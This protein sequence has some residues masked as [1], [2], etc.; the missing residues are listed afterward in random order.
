M[1]SFEGDFKRRPV[2]SLRGASKKEPTSSLLQRN[3]DERK[4]RQEERNKQL[5][6]TR[7]QS[8]LRGSL[9]RQ[10]LKAELRR[11]WDVQ[12]GRVQGGSA[13]TATSLD[14][15]TLLA[16]Q[17]HLVMFFNESVDSQRLTVLCQVI[18]KQ[19]SLCTELLK[20]HRSTWI[21]QIRR[22]LLLCCRML[23]GNS[24]VPIAMPLRMLEVFTD[25]RVFSQ[26]ESIT[27]TEISQAVRD[28]L[29]YLVKQGYY[30]YLR[31][32]ID[33]R[34]P[35]GM[36]YPN[37]P[38]LAK[39]ALELVLR[40]TRLVKRLQEQTTS[41]NIVLCSLCKELLCLQFTEPINSF[42]LPAISQSP[43]AFPVTQLLQAIVS[44][45]QNTWLDVN[46]LGV[47]PTPWL[48][49][50][51]MTLVKPLLATLHN[52]D[53]LRYLHLIKLIF[54]ML[55]GTSDRRFHGNDD[56]SDSE[57]DMDVMENQVEGASS[58]FEIRDH[59]LQTLNSADHVNWLLT[60][61]SKSDV[62]VLTALCSICHTLMVEHKL[63]VPRTKLLYLLA[64]NER[65]LRH[66]WEAIKSVSTPAVTGSQTPLIQ[67]LSSG[68]PLTSTDSDRIIP[69]LSVFCSLF[70]HLL[71]SLHDAEFHGDTRGDA[72]HSLMPFRLDE[73]IHMSLSLRNACLGMIE[74]AH[75]ET[76]PTVTKDYTRAMASVGVSAHGRSSDVASTWMHVFKVT[77]Q[78]VKQ[79]HDRDT[80]K[81][82]CPPNHWLASH[83]NVFTDNRMKGS[84]GHFHP[85]FRPRRLHFMRSSMAV[86]EGPLPMSTLETR[87]MTIL[88]E[89]PF[90]VPFEDRVKIF[91][92]WIH[93]DKDENQGEF[94]GFIA[95]RTIDINIRRNYIYEDAYDRLRPE[96]E[97]NLRK[98]LRVIMRNVQGLE[99]AGIDGGGLTREFL[100]QL[101]KSSFDPNRGFFKSSADEL[102]YPNPQASQLVPD[103]QKHYYF[104]GRMLGKVLYENLLVELPFA[105]F[106][107][108]KLLS[109]HADV[110]IHHLA[111][112][113]PEMYKN[114]LFLKDYTGDITEL[115]LNFTVVDNDLGEMRVYELKT[116]GHDIPVTASN[117]IEYIHLM[118]DYRLNKQMRPH[119]LAFRQGLANV[120]DA[121]WLQMFD[122]QEL[123]VLISGASVPIDVDDLKRNTNYSGGYTVDHPLIENFWKVVDAMDDNQK[124]GLLKFVTSCSRPPLLGF[125][126]LYPPFCI[127][128]GGS[129][130]ER[131]PSASTCMNLL[132]LPEFKDDS[133][134][135]TKLL[136]A[137][138]S[139]AGFELS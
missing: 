13:S 75:P 65:F 4:K 139:E 133:T 124:R 44:T 62:S 128:Y 122:H 63:H 90:V 86:E 60:A 7:I 106:F 87:K 66:L 114:L 111:S 11:Q 36:E 6:A 35:P 43:S 113:D 8:F 1:Y 73:L 116:G 45:N 76:R 17:S 10:R 24:S 135:K 88:A 38:T 80:R 131:L 64:F 109:K 40:P 99:E 32:L 78:L 52:D 61:V 49:Y 119:I 112:L 48:L 136:Y 53:I 83:V 16:L 9:S 125:K 120:I 56:D 42:L 94:A 105:S 12:M 107:L 37:I 28:I 82:F 50:S 21:H 14:P 51:V 118:A 129:D 100:S 27:E 74:C 72:H 55:P 70:G 34:L 121:E 15:D 77:A 31:A 58:L 47:E 134:L 123:Q 127:Q 22:L 33:D 89:M 59:C 2:V 3:Q 69:L 30:R 108:T 102:L 18:L 92:D 79:L 23:R 97:P 67:M 91:R 104:F 85:A 26:S 29:L 41:R 5:S 19:K 132:K 71:L 110:D 57:D 115:G 46:H 137:I 25:E 101:L 81:P 39:T 130:E 98:K 96:N 95:G 20:N 54:P 103:Y 126:E 117:R 93:R 138:D 84:G 68:F